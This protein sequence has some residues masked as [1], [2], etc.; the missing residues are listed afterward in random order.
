MF[1]LN[2]PQT[3]SSKPTLIIALSG[4]VD[5]ICLAH[6]LSQT[7]KQTVILAHFNHK[8]RKESQTE[9]QEVQKFA[10]ELN[11]PLEIGHW[12]NPVKSEEK[13]RIARYAFL[14]KIQK[15]YQAQAIVTAH[16]QDD[17]IETIL[18]NF[19]RGTGL[20]GL[21]GISAFENEIWR[22]FLDIP[23]T[24]LLEYCQKN[25]LHFCTDESNF[26]PKYTRNF[27][28]L[29][30]L[31][32]LKKINPNLNQTLL[33]NSQ[34]YSQITTFLN[35]NL[36]KFILQN[37][38]KIDDFLKL[39]PCLQSELIKQKI[40]PHTEPSFKKVQ[41]ILTLIHRRETGK[42]KKFG[43]LNIK[44]EYDFVLF[45][46]ISVAKGRL[47]KKTELKIKNTQNF[48]NYKISSKMVSKISKQTDSIYLDISQIPLPFYLRTWQK[49]D[50]FQPK[51][52]QGSQ[53]LSD[54]FTN[55][56][57]TQTERKQIP[58]LVDKFDEILAIGNLRIS[59]KVS[60]LSLNQKCLQIKIIKNP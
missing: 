26:D 31:P 10:K 45:E 60:P 44:I 53:K 16:H 33:Q 40:T 8:L 23:K 43:K 17:Q 21:T 46:S 48:G 20:K 24:K 14:R 5:S 30:V 51:G 41:E 29:E 9:E 12:K 35:Q 6:L 56:K 3:L 54:F 19:I 38:I 57:I 13:A 50:R 58:I 37:K 49:G 52:L 39:S 7:K 2:Y 22:P 28:R 36:E 34:N 59:E 18:F 32:L 11:L 55:Q 15:K 47:S 27:L 42:F 25:K 4:G 1:S